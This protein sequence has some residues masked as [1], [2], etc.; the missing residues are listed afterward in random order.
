MVKLII[1]CP[2][3]QLSCGTL[4]RIPGFDP[5]DYSC[6]LSY[7]SYNHGLSGSLLSSI[8]PESNSATDMNIERSNNP[9]LGNFDAIIENM[10][11]IHRYTFFLSAENQDLSK[12]QIT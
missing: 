8:F 10:N 11:Y 9:K 12:P 3:P 4:D 2:L 7:Y 6:L 5:H 1:Q